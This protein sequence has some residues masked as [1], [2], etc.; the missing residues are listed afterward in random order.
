MS[1]S[2]SARQVRRTTLGLRADTPLAPGVPTR[3]K[4]FVQAPFRGERLIVPDQYADGMVHSI[5]IGSREQLMS[6]V[7]TVMFGTTSASMPLQLDTAGPAQEIALVVSR[8]NGGD[9]N[10]ALIG[11]TTGDGDDGFAASLTPP[12][13]PLIEEAKLAVKEAEEA[14]EP[15]ITLEELEASGLY[16]P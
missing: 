12:V 10:A 11:M 5:T 15:G 4:V 9:F 6:A 8:P 13:E 14:Y 2:P 1:P 16:K 3:V 7:P